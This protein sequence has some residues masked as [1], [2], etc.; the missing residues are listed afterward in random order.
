MIDKH[1]YLIMAHNEFDI[2]EKQLILLDDY[3]N[4]IYIHIDKKIKDFN[5][6]YYKNIV[7]FSN[8]YYTE[9]ID[10]RWG[11][12]SQIEC[13]I[14]LLKQALLGNYKYYH[15]LSGVDMP[16]KTQDEIHKFFADNNGSEFIHFSTEYPDM[17]V[18]NRVLHYHFMKYYRTRYKYINYVSRII[19][20]L[21][22]TVQ[23]ISYFKR[24]W[25]SNIKIMYGANWFSITHDLAKYVVSKERWI[26]KNFRYTACADELFLQTIV[27]N[28]NFRNKLYNKNFDN[29]Y[30][31]CMRYIDWGRGTPYI[32]RNEDFQQL[33]K[34]EYIF[35]RKF[36][37]KVD[38]E[39]IQNI[40]NYLVNK[41]CINNDIYLVP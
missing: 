37:S 36:S 18:K 39:V 29:N 26:N 27:Y 1:A 5:F 31:S 9:R 13:E 10:V 24:K 8:V 35:A 25:D 19:N 15:L 4:D 3:R 2:L 30:I 11:D 17:N 16:L 20:I 32:F 34:S 28:S 33:I 22:R 14:I 7:R 41:K 6:D 12:F 23:N 21:F 40:F 38:N